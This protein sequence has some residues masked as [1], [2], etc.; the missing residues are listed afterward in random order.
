MKKLEQHI[1]RKLNPVKTDQVTER[2]H[3]DTDVYMSHRGLNQNHRGLNNSLLTTS[4]EVNMLQPG[5]IMPQRQSI[6]VYDSSKPKTLRRQYGDK[7]GNAPKGIS[8]MDAI[9]AASYQVKQGN[10]TKAG[11]SRQNGDLPSLPLSNGNGH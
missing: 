5:A 11:V 9:N 7:I 3:T 6:P 1:A 2:K 10:T 4:A 8:L